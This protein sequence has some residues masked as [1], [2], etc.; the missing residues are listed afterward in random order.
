MKKRT[1]LW[2]ALAAVLVF[3][4][5]LLRDGFFTRDSRPSREEGTTPVPPEKS[6]SI[7]SPS[8]PPIEP[9][10]GTTGEGETP[11][12]ST[13][14]TTREPTA[15]GL[16]PS[17]P[18]KPLSPVPHRVLKAWA[19]SKSGATSP[20]GMTLIVDPSISNDALATLARDIV[21]NLPDSKLLNVRIYDSEKATTYDWMKDGGAFAGEH[22]VG[23]IWVNEQMGVRKVKVRGEEIELEAVGEGRTSK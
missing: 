13:G 10:P 17:A 5:L 22:L 12:P 18:P 3:G 9:F 21:K 2:L 8:G 11:P 15:Q 14:R 7:G 20:V 16:P 6:G 23:Q 4:S 19:A 1:A